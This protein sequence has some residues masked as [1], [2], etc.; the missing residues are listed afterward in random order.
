MKKSKAINI[1]NNQIKE[2]SDKK[3]RDDIWLIKTRTYIADFFGDKS[4]QID[5]LNNFSF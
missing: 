3:N 5:Y 4:E 1:I 2:L